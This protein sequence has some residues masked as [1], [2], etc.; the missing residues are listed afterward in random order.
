MVFLPSKIARTIEV[1][2]NIGFMLSPSH[3]FFCTRL[4]LKQ[5]VEIFLPHEF[6][7]YFHVSTYHG[8]EDYDRLFNPIIP[9]A[10]VPNFNMRILGTKHPFG[11][12]AFQVESFKKNCLY[13]F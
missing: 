12:V 2:K 3:L 4:Y 11:E 8:L 1:E 9:I 7:N 10:R 13:S 6:A 5:L